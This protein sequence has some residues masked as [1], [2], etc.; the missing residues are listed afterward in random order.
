MITNIDIS[1]IILMK[2]MG[3]IPIHELQLLIPLSTSTPC[4]FSVY[5]LFIQSFWNENIETIRIYVYIQC[6][7]E[8]SLNHL[9]ATK[10]IIFRSFL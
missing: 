10:E 5:S 4:L 7:F 3:P 1:E 6:E 9:S 2:T 8:N